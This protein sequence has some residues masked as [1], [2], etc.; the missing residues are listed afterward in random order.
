MTPWP[1]NKPL[2]AS[3]NNFGYGGSNAHL[4]LEAAPDAKKYGTTNY[5]DIDARERIFVVSAKSSTTLGAIAA[6]LAK[7]VLALRDDKVLGDLAYT[8]SERRSRL[9][10]SLAVRAT[11]RNELA[12]RLDPQL[13]LPHLSAHNRPPRLGF[14]FNGQGGQWYAMG[15]E[16]MKAHPIFNA[17]IQRADQSLRDIGSKWS[18]R[19]QSARPPPPHLLLLRSKTIE[20]RHRVLILTHY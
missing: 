14:V 17:G 3:I 19:G 1:E 4:I 8:L 6:R 7:Y 2:R 13:L 18:L 12:T 20:T 16:L 11:N 9:P 15:R 10:I 5:S